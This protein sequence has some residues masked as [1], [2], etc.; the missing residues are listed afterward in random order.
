M[1]AWGYDVFD[2]DDACDWCYELENCND[3]SLIKETLKCVA[4]SDEEYLDA[5]EASQALAACETV[6]RLRGNFGVQNAN[7]ET[8]DQWVATHS[9]LITDALLPLAHTVIDHVLAD[10]SELRE[11][12]QESESFNEWQASIEN[13]RARLK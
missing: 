1:G 12:W 9:A 2:N 4:Q 5:G 7:T 3:L 6:A 13:L 10:H 11:L 8:V